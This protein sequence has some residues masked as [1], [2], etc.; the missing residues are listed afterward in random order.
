MASPVI[1]QLHADLDAD[2]RRVAKRFK[3]PVIT[4]I[5]RNPDIGNTADVVLT[6]EVD[7]GEAIAA[8]IRS[9]DPVNETLRPTAPTRRDPKTGCEPGC[10]CAEE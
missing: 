7:I 8:L 4:L 9:S 6:D 2:L 1:H 5:V 10:T 3:N